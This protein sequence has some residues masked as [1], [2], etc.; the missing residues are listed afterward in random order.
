VLERVRGFVPLVEKPG[1]RLTAAYSVDLIGGRHDATCG[2]APV[3]AEAAEVE[4]KI[5]DG[6]VLVRDGILATDDFEGFV[7]AGFMK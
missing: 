4:H 6:G 1:L 2:V 7:E 5:N 3:V